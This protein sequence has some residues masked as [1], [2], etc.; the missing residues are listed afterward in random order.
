M[1]SYPPS[2]RR[3]LWLL[4]ICWLAVSCTPSSDP[5]ATVAV[6]P[7]GATVAA[8]TVAVSATSAT[9][10]AVDAPTPTDTPS[11]P[12]ATPTATETPLPTATAEPTVTP[13]VPA[14]AVIEGVGAQLPEGFSLIRFADFTRPTSL[15]FGPDGRLWAAAADGSIHV[16]TDSDGDGRSDADLVTAFGFD[17]PLGLA[18]APDGT[19]YVSSI[20]RGV[21]EPYVSDTGQIVR[22]Q[23]T[24]GDLVADVIEPVVSGLP[25][26][27]H[28]NN[29]LRF[30]PDGRLYVGIGSTCDVCD[31]PDPRSATIMAF[32]L[33]TGEGEIIATGLRNPFDLIFDPAS[34]AL[35][36]TDNGRD[37]LG[38]E[39]PLEELN[40]I[41]AGGD[42]GWP[43]CWNDGLGSGCAGTTTAVAFFEARSST[44][45][46]AF[47]T[48]DRFPAAYRGDL[49]AAV[50]GSYEADVTRGIWRVALQPSG[51]TYVAE[52][53]WFLEWPGAWLLGLTEGPD[54]A[55]YFGD[56]INGG[57]WRISYGLP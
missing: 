33:A 50:W 12:T 25:H 21:D 19:A 6:P 1:T 36:A 17:T 11:L 2:L 10:A 56:Y 46:L 44:N 57:I 28:Q 38:P 5:L 26:G 55:L 30:G 14:S 7:T 37:D 48:G 18:V 41:V 13:T 24:D 9:T 32:D 47:Y 31:E 54:G 23:D 42:Y 22:L 3:A 4:G 20:K 45:S 16:L 52:T 8:P 40:H 39:A 51:D 34:G 43:A 15:T 35:F 49:F 53:A 27:R 29:N